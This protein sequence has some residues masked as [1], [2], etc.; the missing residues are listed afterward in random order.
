[1]TPSELF[2][3][4]KAKYPIH[5]VECVCCVESTCNKRGYCP[6]K[7]KM[8]VLDF[9]KIKDAYYNGQKTATP[10]S[11][12]AVCLGG[13]NKYF[14]FVEMKGWDNYII[15]LE[16]QKKS[17]EDTIGDYNLSGKL[18]NSQSLCVLLANDKDLFAHMPVVFLLVT[19]IDVKK[20]GAVALADMLNKL[21]GNSSDIYSQCISK[22]QKTLD[23]DIHIEHQYVY[24]R[25]FD[26]AISVL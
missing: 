13:L 21:G 9:D 1:M 18:L 19:D 3:C 7:Q 12:D 16:K 26:N 15:F 2:D 17:V 11:V 25:E 24:C 22:S 5:E 8:P 10:A 14:C 4:I 23:S 6:D 20:H